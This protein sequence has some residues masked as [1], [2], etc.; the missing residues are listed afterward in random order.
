MRAGCR[1]LA[2][3]LCLNG[4]IPFLSHAATPAEQAFIDG[5][6]TAQSATSSA[7][8][9]I[10]NGTIA[11]T[12]N[13][14]DPSYYNYSGTAP[15]AGYF[16]GGSGDTITPGAGKVTACQTGPVNPNAFLQQ[17]CDAI[18]YMARNPTIRPQFTITPGDPMI[19]NSKQIT[20]NAG[21]LAAQSLGF[22][23]PS[24]MGSFT[25]CQTTTTSTSPTYTTEV[26]NEYL[27]TT[28][29]MCTVGR[30]VV[31]DARSNFQ[32]NET[33]NAFETLKCRRSS[34]VTCAGGGDGCDRGGIVPNSWAGDMNTTWLPDDAGNYILQFGT[35]ADNYWC[36]YAI[37]QDRTLTF[38][39]SDVALISRFALT[40]AAFDDWIL[41]EV[42]GTIV[43]IGPYGG[44]RLE[45]TPAPATLI[46]GYC[47]RD[48]YGNGYSCYT[49][50]AWG[51]SSFYG[52]YGYCEARGN[53]F[54]GYGG[55][56]YCSNIQPGMVQYGANS[57]G[58]PELRTSW[59]IGLNIDLRPYL[60]N[61]SNTIFMRVIV[62]GCGE[63][64]IQMTT[65]QVCPLNC[66]VS[67][68]NQC[69]ALEARAR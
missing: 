1:N 2:I 63:G 23:D 36:G 7:S 47:Y 53:Y 67:T 10:T 31:V 45:V 39:I 14:F 64:A 25:A 49:T 65:R 46:P 19:L 55:T 40:R 42:N 9:N 50:N 6:A 62:A 22:A 16:M 59:N 26:C 11:T 30:N 58:Y 33:A 35:I 56:W 57:Y 13:S 66:S 52:S 51:D 27:S 8:T 34:S 4:A 28:T 48:E 18:S 15:E 41:V 12:V 69:G 38:S 61:G 5:Q 24:A 20:A 44:D 43:Y 32:C 29:N 37:T 3:V 54:D 60:R 68:N 17:N 21:T